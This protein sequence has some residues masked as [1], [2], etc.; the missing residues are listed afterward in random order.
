MS[1]A[2]FRIYVYTAVETV[3]TI[4]DMMENYNIALK[5]ELGKKKLL[6]ELL[7]DYMHKRDQV[8]NKNFCVF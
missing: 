8:R 5:D 6:E 3:E 2:L 7:N 4:Q 1:I